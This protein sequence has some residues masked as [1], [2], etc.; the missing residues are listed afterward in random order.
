[1]RIKNPKEKP[2]A[3]KNRNN[4]STARTQERGGD[5]HEM[6]ESSAFPANPPPTAASV[7][8]LAKDAE[9]CSSTLHVIAFAFLLPSFITSDPPTDPIMAGCGLQAEELLRTSREYAAA[10]DLE[11]WKAQQHAL[12]QSQLAKAKKKLEVRIRESVRREE[13]EVVGQLEKTRRDLE[14]AGA[15]LKEAQREQAR[16]S[17]QLDAR[18]AAMEQRRLKVAAQHESEISRLEDQLRREREAHRVALEALEAKDREKAFQLQVAQDRLRCSEDAFERLRRRVVRYHDHLDVDEPLREGDDGTEEDG[19]G[20]AAATPSSRSAG[21]GGVPPSVRDR[22]PAVRSASRGAGA[23][24]GWPAQQRLVEELQQVRGS[25]HDVQRI[26]NETIRAKE[27]LE[28]L[29]AQREE[30]AVRAM[31][32]CAELQEALQKREMAYLEEKRREL[33]AKE[34]VLALQQIGVQAAGHRPDSPPAVSASYIYYPMDPSRSD[35]VGAVAK[36]SL[37]RASGAGPRPAAAQ[38]HGVLDLLGGLK[39]D[40]EAKLRQQQAERERQNRDGWTQTTKTKAHQPHGTEGAGGKMRA[41]SRGTGPIRASSRVGPTYVFPSPASTSSGRF[42]LAEQP[43]MVSV[44]ITSDESVED[45]GDQGAAIIPS[46]PRS[47]SPAASSSGVGVPHEEEE[48]A[49]GGGENDELL[50]SES[51]EADAAAV[52]REIDAMTDATDPASD[53]PLLPPPPPRRTGQ[54]NAAAGSSGREPP[55]RSSL[56]PSRPSSVSAPYPHA[57]SAGSFTTTAAA[58]REAAECASNRSRGEVSQDPL[59]PLPQDFVQASASSSSDAATTLGEMEGFVAQLKHNLK[60]LAET[61]VYPP[62]HPVLV[63]MRSKVALYEQYLAEHG[64]Q[65][66]GGGG[67]MASPPALLQQSTEDAVTPGLAL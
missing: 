53:V 54:G 63:E 17:E 62:D 15:Q 61:K 20:T 67:A 38:R 10:F 1:M 55:P 64:V 4:N 58:T 6:E 2:K 35:I 33:Q 56:P 47:C 42:T 22:R 48:E 25:L 39:R 13:Q 57:S 65:T 34:R 50:F 18:E 52:L 26:L 16:R 3:Q 12:F 30:Q 24:E 21:G 19:A 51:D 9:W 66:P 7:L 46:P 60:S 31:R 8:L 40:V 11:I 32:C 14:A 27:Q 23:G 45:T 59:Y 49:R 5:T 41:A 43:I 29:V 44:P 37:H 28:T 36:K